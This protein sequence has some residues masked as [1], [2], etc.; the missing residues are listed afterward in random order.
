MFAYAGIELIGTAAGE[1]QDARKV[2]PRSIN[3][4]M[5]RI[6]LFYVGSVV[7]LVLLLPW[8]ETPTPTRLASARRSRGYHR[9]WRMSQGVEAQPLDARLMRMSVAAYGEA[10]RV[11]RE[12]RRSSQCPA[13]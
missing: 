6:A 11:L 13:A 12:S 9:A 2:L 8:T 1:A 5:W 3:S 10:H 7:L 4:V